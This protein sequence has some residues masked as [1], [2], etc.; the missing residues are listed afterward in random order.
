MGDHGALD[1]GYP[2]GSI[3]VWREGEGL[4]L[5]PQSPGPK[6]NSGP[7]AAAEEREAE[8]NGGK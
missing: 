2:A 6:E 5:L 1:R 8:V 7:A 4:P 3:N